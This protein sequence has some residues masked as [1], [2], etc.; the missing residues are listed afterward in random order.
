[1]LRPEGSHIVSSHLITITT[2]TPI[3]TTTTTTTT[4]IDQQPHKYTL[5]LSLSLSLHVSVAGAWRF[6]RR[7]GDHSNNVK[8][9]YIYDGLGMVS[10]VRRRVW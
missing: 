1:M 3:T 7:A 5:S 6:Q 10:C 8:Y 2:T 4:S 9:I